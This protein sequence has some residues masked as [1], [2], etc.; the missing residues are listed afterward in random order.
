MVNIISVISI[1][2][3]VH[4]F[5]SWDQCWASFLTVAGPQRRPNMDRMR[6]SMDLCEQTVAQMFNVPIAHAKNI[7]AI[8]GNSVE[9]IR[10]LR[11]DDITKNM[12][13]DPNNKVV[14]QIRHQTAGVRAFRIATVYSAHTCHVVKTMFEPVQ[15][16]QIAVTLTVEE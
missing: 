13:L 8:F 14:L 6:Q 16:G 15:Q 3:T 2:D 7:S 12:L 11:Q 4:H 1:A 5:D 10:R 9:A